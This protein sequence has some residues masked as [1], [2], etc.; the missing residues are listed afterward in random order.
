MDQLQSNVEKLW[1]VDLLPFSQN[2]KHVLR[3][4]QDKDVIK[5]L[6]QK[7][8][9]E[10]IN[11]VK[12]Y[13]TPLLRIKNAP[14]LKASPEAVM[15]ALRRIE[16]QLTKDPKHAAIYEQE[17]Q[18]LIEAG[19]VK[20]LKLNEIDLGDESWY[21]LYHLVE[22]NGKHRVVFNCSYQYQGESLNAYLL[23]GPVQGPSL[24]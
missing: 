2:S 17:I 5:C 24:I 22:H 11:G 10:E 15:P 18:K 4:K 14:V 9:C 6:D 19:C 21:I 8:K 3:S 12:R 13:A 16:R 23:P 20:K 1:Q 7:T